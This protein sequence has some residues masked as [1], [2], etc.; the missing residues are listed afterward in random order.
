[1]KIK[2][3]PVT[4]ETLVSVGD[5]VVRLAQVRHEA[6][7]PVLLA[8][9]T[10]PT[11]SVTGESLRG[12]VR[13][14]PAPPGRVLLVVS[15]TQVLTRCVTLPAEDPGELVT[16][17]RYAVADTLPYALDD[18]VVAVQPLRSFEKKTT[19]L[20]VITPRA[21]LDRLLS[22]LAPAGLTPHAIALG[23]EGL[24]RW[25]QRLSPGGPEGPRLVLETLGDTLELAI[26]EGER[27]WQVR[28]L[29]LPALTERSAAWFV[30]QVQETLQGY[31]QERVGPA[32]TALTVSGPLLGTQGIIATLAEHL[33]LPVTMAD[34]TAGPFTQALAHQATALTAQPWSD[35]FGLA[36]APTALTL[37]LLPAEVTR[38]HARDAVRHQALAVVTWFGIC[39]W[40]GAGVFGVAWLQSTRLHQTLAHQQTRWAA[41]ATHA[42]AVARYLDQV[43]EAQPVYAA[44]LTLLTELQTSLSEAV[45]VEQVSLRGGHLTLQGSAATLGDVMQVVEAWSRLPTLTDVTLPH[46]TAAHGGRVRFTVEARRR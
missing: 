41:T 38:T 34:P 3:P 21:A 20:A 14:L 46:A 26:V 27:L 31:M 10:R 11:A 22:L 9:T 12:L 15:K 23:A 6:Q 4:V 17:A 19:V 2:A 44:S 24:A 16:M 18:C 1:M 43:M 13:T 36:L 5:Q 33:A 40:L 32:V 45:T 39:A 30:T 8:L 35:L 25:H 29:P 7:G 37:D 42:Q 28:S